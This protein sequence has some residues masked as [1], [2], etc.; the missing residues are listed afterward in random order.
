MFQYN[1]IPFT[2]YQTIFT[3]CNSYEYP[4]KAVRPKYSS[5]DST[6]FQNEFHIQL[7]NWED[8]L[9]EFIKPENFKRK[10]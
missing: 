5:L 4:T 3:A 8:S 9:E 10:T 1:L 7:S 2:T 6:K